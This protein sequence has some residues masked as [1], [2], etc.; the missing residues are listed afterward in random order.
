MGW[1]LSL[2]RFDFFAVTPNVPLHYFPRVFQEK[3]SSW[4]ELAALAGG[5]FPSLV[6]IKAQ[7]R[8]VCY[9]NLNQLVKL[10]QALSPWQNRN[11]SLQMSNSQARPLILWIR[12]LRP[13][14]I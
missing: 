6:R 10:S 11:Y 14:N 1:A 3:E 12:K 5:E 13:A 8:K 7:M 4:I 9:G 2:I